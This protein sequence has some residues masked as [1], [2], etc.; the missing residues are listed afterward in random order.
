MGRSLR[1]ANRAGA[2]AT[3]NRV[4]R[5]DIVIKEP[6][7]IVVPRCAHLDLVL[8]VR[9]SERAARPPPSLLV[10]ELGGRSRDV[11][12]VHDDRGPH[13]AMHEAMDGDLARLIETHRKAGALADETG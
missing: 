8:R 4:L 13:A 7:L 9:K 12:W 11:R 6:T 5:I 10:A 3:I 2:N 1:A